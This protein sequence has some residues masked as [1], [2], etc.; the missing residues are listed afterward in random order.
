MRQSFLRSALLFVYIC[1]SASI[2]NCQPMVTINQAAGQSDPTTTVPVKFT[3][4]FD[5]DVTGFD[6]SDISFA[7]STVTGA[8][9]ATITGTG[10]TYEVSVSEITG[11]GNV[12]ASAKY[13]WPGKFGIHIN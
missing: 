7:G 11:S 10:S 12:V 8:L 3:V 6:A 9:V 5:Q 13:F 1:V 4:V 2:A